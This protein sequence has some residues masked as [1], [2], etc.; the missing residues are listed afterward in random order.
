MLLLFL[1]PFNSLRTVSNPVTLEKKSVTQAELQA[2]ERSGS[3]PEA[4]S[5]AELLSAEVL[6][7]FFLTPHLRWRKS[8]LSGLTKLANHFFKFYDLQKDFDGDAHHHELN[9]EWM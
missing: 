6:A 2:W 8:D 7:H 3:Q 9:H 4:W 1:P 5:R